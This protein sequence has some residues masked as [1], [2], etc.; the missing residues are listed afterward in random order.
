MY[1]QFC[2]RFCDS[3]PEP[4]I[5]ELRFKGFTTLFLLGFVGGIRDQMLP[6]PY[7]SAKEVHYLSRT[8]EFNLACFNEQLRRRNMHPKT[9]ILFWIRSGISL[10]YRSSTDADCNAV[11]VKALRYRRFV[12]LFSS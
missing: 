7:Q 6:L 8:G 1:L 12:L 11:K 2:T 4:L 9:L 5:I 10:D 3:D